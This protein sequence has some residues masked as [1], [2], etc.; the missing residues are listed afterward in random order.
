M[1]FKNVIIGIDASRAALAQHTGTEAYAYRLIQALAEF[2]SKQVQFRLYTDR[3]P[4][5]QPWPET[6]FV[7]TRSIPFPRLWTH[8]R[9]AAELHT[10]PP[11][12]LFV[13]AH[14][15]PLYCP[16]PAVV[17]VHDLAYRFYPETYTRQQRLYLDWSTRRHTRVARHIIAD[18]QATKTDLLQEYH[19]DPA[20]ISVV[21]LG[22]DPALQPVDYRQAMLDKYG[23]KQPYLLYIGTLQPRKNL[24]R[25][26]TA[27]SHISQK[28][29]VQ[30]VL[31]GGKGWLYE[32]IFAEVNRLG[33]QNRVL[34]PGY[35]NEA[36]K[37]SLISGA[38]LYVYPSLYEGFGIPILEAMAC[39]T[40]ILTSNCS[41]MAE[42][43][44]DAAWLIDP[45]DT[46]AMVTGLDCLL[47][48]VTLRDKLIQCGLQRVQDFSWEQAAKQVFTVLTEMVEQ[49]K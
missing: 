15:L 26:L 14:V 3:A 48:D 32:Q 39:G 42:I 31:A 47:T 41:S 1:G 11:D 27:F 44:A 13:P 8:V 34:F 12:V 40:P 33:L 19:A 4:Q 7:E 2:G 43:A 38:E 5:T 20:K 45:L 46:E 23:I 37:A 18:S 16:V 28:H 21:H 30:L 10:H 22:R 25:L 49:P 6:P 29:P 36:D 35:V 17:T 9:L 24:L